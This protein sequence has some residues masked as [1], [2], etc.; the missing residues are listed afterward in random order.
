M[1]ILF[2]IF[3][4]ASRGKPLLFHKKSSD[5][6][7]DQLVVCSVANAGDETLLK[8]ANWCTTI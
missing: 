4:K 5:I 1:L 7:I 2:K 6:K 3:N 8:S